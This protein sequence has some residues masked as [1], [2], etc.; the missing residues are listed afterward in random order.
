MVRSIILICVQQKF[1][2]PPLLPFLSSR[3]RI[4]W[5]IPTYAPHRTRCNCLCNAMLQGKQ[6][7]PLEIN[8]FLVCQNVRTLCD[9]GIRQ[10]AHSAALH[11]YL[12]SLMTLWGRSGQM[13]KNVSKAYGCQPAWLQAQT[14]FSTSSWLI[15]GLEHIQYSTCII[16]H[17]SPSPEQWTQPQLDGLPT[18]ET[19]SLMK[20]QWTKKLNTTARNNC[21]L[22]ES[23]PLAS[24]CQGYVYL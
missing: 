23:R 5:I 1:N 9:R 16:S 17:G 21:C 2:I 19:I 20:W 13:S 18:L 3:L 15:A 10:V 4:R 14:H 24:L 6:S 11:P 8:V 22:L 7:V 12:C